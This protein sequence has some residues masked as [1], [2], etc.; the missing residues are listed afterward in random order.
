MK[1]VG[2]IGMKITAGQ[3]EYF[4]YTGV[5]AELEQQGKGS[6]RPESAWE[7][8]AKESDATR[9]AANRRRTI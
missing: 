3:G 1:T 5:S 7:P 4:R 8:R 6:S 9:H 2:E